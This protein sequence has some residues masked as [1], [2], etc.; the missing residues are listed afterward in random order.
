M[1]IFYLPFQLVVRVKYNT[2]SKYGKKE[3]FENFLLTGQSNAKKIST[4]MILE[5]PANRVDRVQELH[6]FIGHVI[7]EIIENSFS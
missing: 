3:R 5:V 6:I 1:V 4:N 2:S 7:C